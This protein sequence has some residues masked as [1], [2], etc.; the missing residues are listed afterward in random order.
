MMWRLFRGCWRH[1]TINKWVVFPSSSSSPCTVRDLLPSIHIP[2]YNHLSFEHYENCI[3]STPTNVFWILFLL[4]TILIQLYNNIRLYI[5]MIFLPQG[6]HSYFFLKV[7]L[8]NIHETKNWESNFAKTS[9]FR[10]EWCS[11]YSLICCIRENTGL[12]TWVENIWEGSNYTVFHKKW[13]FKTH[14]YLIC[15]EHPIFNLL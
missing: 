5:N 4:R 12:V 14:L 8:V 9:S 3:E 10:K 2:I 13:Y 11:T 6:T 7:S 1:I 15:F